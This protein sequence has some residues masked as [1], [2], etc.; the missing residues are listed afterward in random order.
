MKKKH[1]PWKKETS[2]L[3]QYGLLTLASFLVV[4]LPLYPKL[5]LFD[6]IPGYIVRVRVEDILILFTSIVWA[7]QAYRKKVV[8]K[9]P[10]NPLIGLYAVAGIASIV[11]ALFIL[12]TIP[13]ETLHLAKSTLH[14]FRYIE[15][16]MLFFIFFSSIQKKK[17]VVIILTVWVATVAAIGF[18]G[19]GQKYFYWPVYSTMNREFSKGVRL[20]LTEHARVQ[21]TFG[22]H[23]DLAAY[24]VIVLPLLFSVGVIVKKTSV[25]IGVWLTFALGV[26]LLVVSGARMSFASYVAA[27]T[28]TIVLLAF[29]KHKWHDRLR[30]GASRLG[31][32]GLLTL[33][34]FVGFGEDMYERFLQTL[35]A[36]PELH[37]TYHNANDQRKEIL[38]EYVL[39][40]LGIQDMKVQRPDNSITI[41]DA[42][43]MV[44]SDQQ[45]TPL[46]SDS[47]KR[48]SDVYVDVPDIQ[49]VATTSATGETTI[50]YIATERVYSENAL[51][52]GLSLAIRLDT[53]WP[54]AIAGFE[55]NP[56][57][58]T[59]YATLN[60][61]SPT[62]FTEADSTDNNFLR[63][64]GETGLF[65]F[66]T[67]YGII[68]FAMHQ[69][70]IL[71]RSHSAKSIETAVA[72]AFFGASFGLLLNA[73]Y[74]DVFA[75]SK[76]ALAYW[77]FAGIVI[78]L[79]RISPEKKVKKASK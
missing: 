64:L 32:V 9:N 69:A 10:L 23:Y 18:Y 43:V 48:P 74:I 31:A 78:A 56:L 73:L 65:G 28:L 1:A 12:G 45:P 39:V 58:G 22:G 13:L 72:F 63:T 60:K 16:F 62:H 8:W 40:P 26:W 49:E 46:D 70:Y 44:S 33:V 24:L 29:K 68:L 79:A 71:A 67:F 6:V 77:S 66:I 4:F 21:S 41:D 19:I 57:L 47:S 54:Q 7:I 27:I 35:E 37:K 2:W 36:Y 20:I 17:D 3:D 52:H 50:T 25:R 59:G 15:Y 75:A 30:W 5:P 51:R 76:V 55:R 38:R 42:A 53:L 11:S 34:L 14:F 61:Q